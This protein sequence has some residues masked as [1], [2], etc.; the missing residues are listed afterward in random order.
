M[1]S[2]FVT[3]SSGHTGA[4]IIDILRGEARKGAR[5]RLL[6]GFSEA[7]KLPEFSSEVEARICH[8]ANPAQML[9][10]LKGV[11]HAYL[12]VPF[13]RNMVEWGQQFVA[14]A[15]SCDVKFIVRLSG[16][17]AALDSK[18]AMGRLHGQIDQLVKD[19]GIDYCILRCNSFMQNFSGHYAAMIRHGKLRLAHGDARFG[20]IDTQDIASVAAKILLTPSD[21]SS[22]TLNLNGPQNLSNQEAVGIMAGLLGREIAY[23][24]ISDEHANKLLSNMGLTAWQR[25][26]LSSLDIYFRDGYAQGNGDQ[27][28]QVLGRKAN[29]FL[30]FAEANI[31]HWQ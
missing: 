6:A 2:I 25:S 15:I 16:L 31:K 11:E 21:Y 17:G 23:F 19:S 7:D 28:E 14:A 20:F 26:I 3:G 1:H 4:A 10:A 18:S 27:V 12:M 22:M 29:N 8:Y 9:Q 5:L 30:S 13:S 24:Q